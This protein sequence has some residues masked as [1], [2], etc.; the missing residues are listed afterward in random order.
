MRTLY[1]PIIPLI[2]LLT[3]FPMLTYSAPLDSVNSASDSGLTFIQAVYDAGLKGAGCVDLSPDAQY[4]YVASSTSSAVTVYQRSDTTGR[5]NFVQVIRDGDG[6]NYLEGAQG[7]AVSPDGGSVYVTSWRDNSLTVFGRNS[8]TGKLTFLEDFVDGVDGIISLSRASGVIVSPDSKHVYVASWVD[9]TV[10]VFERNTTTGE[11]TFLEAEGAVS[12]LDTTYSVAIS[13]DGKFVFAANYGNDSVTVFERDS[14]T[15]HLTFR[16]NIPSLGNLDGAF[17]LTV[18]GDGKHLYVASISIDAV[19]VYQ[20]DQTTGALTHVETE[21]NGIDG[22]EGLEGVQAVTVSHNG[23]YLY[24]AGSFDHA[25]VVFERNSSNGSLQ[26]IDYIDWDDGAS[27]MQSPYWI[28]LDPDDE[29]VYVASYSYGAIEVFARDPSNGILTIIEEQH[30]GYGLMGAVEVATSPQGCVFAAGY[31]SQAIV[32]LDSDE[33]TGLLT[34]QNARTVDDTAGLGGAVG[35]TASPDGN[36]IYVAGHDA[37]AIVAYRPADC[38][39]LSLVDTY[40]DGDPDIDGLGGAR[41]IAISPDGSL[42]YVASDGDDALAIFNRNTTSGELTFNQA[43]FDGDGGID[44]LNGAYSVAVSPDGGNIY[45]ASIYDDAIAIFHWTGDVLGY[46]GVVKDGIGGVDGLDG[47]NS[48]VVSPDGNH[49][50]VAS[51]VDDAVA[52]FERNISSGA[53]TY[54]GM[55]QDGVDGVDGLDGARSI[56]I[57]PDGSQLY[58]ASQYDDALAVFDR[59]EDGSL[60]FVHAYINNIE[61]VHGIETADGVAVSANGATIYVSG[62]DGDAIAAFARFRTYLPLVMR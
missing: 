28:T 26:Y 6:A 43:F 49:V 47:A 51:R 1:K 33:A 56:A 36:Y 34:Y 60:E 45:V 58:V 2:I 10:S 16:F 37:D 31:K 12:G 5:L 62:Y 48:V 4:L 50:Y 38:S 29:H 40:V 54:L 18:S 41:D 13:P 19:A 11:L 46:E 22:V 35:V 17:Q 52:M 27:Q 61:G 42:L 3:A 53:L 23:E 20:I 30:S 59:N 55:M 8:D 9:D 7:V 25:I 39:W 15:G 21:F 57:N 14:T 32:I 44:G 24:A